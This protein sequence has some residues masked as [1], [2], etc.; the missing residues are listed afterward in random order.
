MAMCRFALFDPAQYSPDGAY[1]SWRAEGLD[2]R[3]LDRLYYEAA[4]RHLPPD[5]NRLGRDDLWGGMADLGDDVVG[6]YRCFDGG[7]DLHGRPGRFVILATLL[8]RED[9]A[10]RNATPVLRSNTAEWVTRRAKEC[11][12]AEPPNLAEDVEL[13]TATGE[14]EPGED[15]LELT[16]PDAVERAGRIFGRLP[17]GEGWRCEIRRT[18]E[19]PGQVRIYRASRSA[20][21]GPGLDEPADNWATSTTAGGDR[22]SSDAIPASAASGGTRPTDPRRDRPY[23]NGG[24]ARGATPA[25]KKR[26]IGILALLLLAGGALFILTPETDQ[27]NAEGPPSSKVTNVPDPPATRP[28]PVPRLPRG[29]Q[30]ARRTDRLSP[31]TQ[32]VDR[33]NKEASEPWHIE[34]PGRRSVVNTPVEPEGPSPAWYEQIEIPISRTLIGILILVGAVLVLFPRRQ[35]SG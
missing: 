30:E 27:K 7:R 28:L 34:T 32:P 3:Q 9:V 33:D 31:T 26:G 29:R 17:S 13:P 19:I 14:E 15:P 2:P 22:L 1:W 8:A 23:S 5:P 21:S 35:R 16:G 12:V 10:G 6:V 18:S 24:R 11:P 20:R 25:G 4:A